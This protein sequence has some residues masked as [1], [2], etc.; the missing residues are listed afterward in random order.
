MGISRTLDRGTREYHEY[1]NKQRKSFEYQ[2]SRSR[3]V[4]THHNLAST[5]TPR[6][7]SSRPVSKGQLNKLV[8]PGEMTF[9]KRMSE[10]AMVR[11]IRKRF[12]KDIDRMSLNGGE[13]FIQ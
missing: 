13:R 9:R 7:A 8:S 11:L 5:S 10:K 2:A 4:C 1:R 12:K 3:S 6:S